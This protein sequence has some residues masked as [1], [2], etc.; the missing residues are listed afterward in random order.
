MSSSASIWGSRVAGL[1]MAQMH[2]VDADR[3]CSL[4]DDDRFERALLNTVLSERAVLRQHMVARRHDRQSRQ[5]HGAELPAP[6][7]EPAFRIAIA[8]IHIEIGTVDPVMLG[9]PCTQDRSG[10]NATRAPP[11]ALHFLQG[12]DVGPLD[13]AGDASEVVALVFP[14]SVLD[15]VS[16]ELHRWLTARAASDRFVSFSLRA[17]ASQ[18]QHA[19]I[20]R[21][22]QLSFWYEAERFVG[23]RHQGL[24]TFDFV[25]ADVDHAQHDDFLA[26]GAQ[27]RHVEVTGGPFDRDDVQPRLRKPAQDIAVVVLV[28]LVRDCLCAPAACWDSRGK[29]GRQTTRGLPDPRSSVQVLRD[30]MPCAASG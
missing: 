24:D 11:M 7:D 18:L 23:A 8:G 28:G 25:L 14:E 22:N 10:V 26:D 30:P 6:I 1:Q 27:Y 4:G 17:R 15:V 13:L 16:D 20:R 19:T 29:Y 3:A 2:R 21:Q 5:N 12:D 9:K